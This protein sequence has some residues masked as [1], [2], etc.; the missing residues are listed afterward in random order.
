MSDM[1][2][3]RLLKNIPV[4]IITSEDTIE[5]EV[6]AFDLGASDIVMKP[7]E[8]HVV[9]RRVQNAIELNLHREH[10]EELV[11]LQSVK[12]RESRDV[13]MDALSSVV[14]HRSVE[15]G[16]H[17]LR[18]RMFTKILLENIMHS[19]PEYDL[20]E[21]TIN[22]IASASALHDIGKISIPMLF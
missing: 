3:T 5:S 12:L 16:Q 21:R 19:Y 15:S 18:I 22:I 7:F 2:R 14:E 4:I 10:L 1:N 13:L 17:I 11:E 6:R 9:K 8:P 20:S